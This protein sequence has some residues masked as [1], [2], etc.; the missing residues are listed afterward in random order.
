MGDPETE[1]WT[2]GQKAILADLRGEPDALAQAERNLELTDRL[3]D[4]FSR[5]WALVY[6]SLRAARHRGRGGCAESDRAGRATSTARRWAAAARRRPGGPRCRAQ[7]LVRVGRTEE[8]LKEAERAATIA[9]ERGMRWSQ[10][11]TLRALAEARVASGEIDG[12]MEAWDEGAEVARQ[13]GSAVELEA[14]EQER[15][16]ARAA[17]I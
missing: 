16:A 14:I 15:E 2:R 10:P 8:G 1:S 12:A 4:V 7:A 13:I 5:T 11:R 3:G 6:V 9:H 17:T